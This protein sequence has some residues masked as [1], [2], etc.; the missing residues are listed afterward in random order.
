MYST[1]KCFI[2]TRMNTSHDIY[3]ALALKGIILL[4]GKEY[5]LLLLFPAI[6]CYLLEIKIMNHY[7][8]LNIFFPEQCFLLVDFFQL[9]LKHIL[10]RIKK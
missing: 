5:L 4:I 1:G 2:R 7:A 6:P 10:I 9:S 8:F 3:N